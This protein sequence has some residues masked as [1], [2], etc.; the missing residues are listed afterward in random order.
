M[1]TLVSATSATG[2]VPTTCVAERSA[3]TGR[4]PSCGISVSGLRRRSAARRSELKFVV[5][6]EHAAVALHESDHWIG[7]R[8]HSECKKPQFSRR[9]HPCFA[10]GRLDK[11]HR[12]AET[13]MLAFV[14]VQKP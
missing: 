13:E 10:L 11:S 9:A 8:Q 4:G 6:A 5:G 7:L 14:S 2:P 12:S 1:Y 3:E